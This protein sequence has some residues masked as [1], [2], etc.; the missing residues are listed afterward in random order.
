[1][2]EKK[3]GFTASGLSHPDD[4]DTVGE[5]IRLQ[6][7]VTTSLIEFMALA[8]DPE[9]PKQRRLLWDLLT[10]AT[11]RMQALTAALD[12]VEIRLSARRMPP[13]R[14]PEEQA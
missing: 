1:M 11:E 5:N 12:G 2:T 9:D 3:T 7:A 8:F 10:I 13:A 6:A 4:G 14:D